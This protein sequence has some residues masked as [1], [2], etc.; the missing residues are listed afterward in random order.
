MLE[1]S[2]QVDPEGTAAGLVAG[3]ATDAFIVNR[4]VQALAAALP[5]ARDLR[6]KGLVVELDD[7]GSAFGKQFKRAARCGARW[8]LVLG[9]DEVKRGELRLKPLQQSGD[10]C[11]VRL[12]DRD[13]I[14]ATLKSL[15]G[16]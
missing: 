12:A 15:Q 3:S 2:A 1:A 14:V 16:K 11:V 6:A 7:S 4:G 10:E 9:D 13:A 5:L 8:A